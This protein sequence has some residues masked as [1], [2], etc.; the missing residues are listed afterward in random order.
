MLVANSYITRAQKEVLYYKENLS[1]QY[2]SD[3]QPF[4]TEIKPYVIYVDDN[5]LSSE[6]EYIVEVYLLL[7]RVDDSK[8]HPHFREYKKF[9][10]NSTQ[11]TF[12]LVKPEFDGNIGPLNFSYG[13]QLKL[14]KLPINME[15]ELG[16]SISDFCLGT[17]VLINEDVFWEENWKGMISEQMK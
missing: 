7:R 5:K 3:F 10:K 17:F 14:Y 8:I 4:Y 11:F 15:L 13:Y 1:I 16:G 6:F 12:E 2:L 9:F